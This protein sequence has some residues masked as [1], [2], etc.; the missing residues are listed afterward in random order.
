[1]ARFSRIEN[2]PDVGW[3]EV[4]YEEL[5]LK[6]VYE[7]TPML[8]EI[9]KESLSA[10]YLHPTVVAATTPTG[11]AI[12]RIFAAASSRMI[13]TVFSGRMAWCRVSALSRFLAV[14]SRTLP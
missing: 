1:M 11:S 9:V 5:V 2:R 8:V 14:L 10:A 12:S 13:P 4:T 7:L 6:P 3:C